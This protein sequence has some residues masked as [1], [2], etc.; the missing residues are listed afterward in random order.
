MNTIMDAV[1]NISI[2]DFYHVLAV[3]YNN[4]ISTVDM[5]IDQIRHDLANGH[6]MVNGFNGRSMVYSD[7]WRTLIAY[8]NTSITISNMLLDSD[9]HE[10]QINTIRIVEQRENINILGRELLRN[11]YL[12]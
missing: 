5:I 1:I 12:R 3:V 10:Y 11:G 2:N 7:K 6:L 4:I 8:H 9:V